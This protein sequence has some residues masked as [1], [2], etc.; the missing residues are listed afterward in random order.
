MVVLLIDENKSISD[1]IQKC[2][3]LAKITSLQIIHCTSGKEAIEKLR[4]E[5]IDAVVTALYLT[6]ITGIT[7]A[8]QIR[9]LDES[10]PIAIFTHYSSY[11]IIKEIMSYGFQYWNKVTL[12]GAPKHLAGKLWA[13][14]NKVNLPDITE[15]PIVDKTLASKII[16]GENRLRTLDFPEHLFF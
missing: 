1:F 5:K 15:Y 3:I 2:L 10:I 7:L 16:S 14:A 13:L 11:D 6:D 4:T 12:L 8:T 9:K